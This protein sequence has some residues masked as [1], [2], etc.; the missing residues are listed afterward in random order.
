[1][2]IN[3]NEHSWAS[4]SLRFG[5]TVVTD[6]KGVKYADEIEGAEPVFGTG[7]HARGRTAGRYKVGDCSITFY[8]SGH[9]KLLQGL[10]NGFGDVRGTAVVQYRE[11]SD[12]ITDTLE[13]VRIMG[14]D[15]GA[16]DG[17]DPLEVEVK[18]SP[19]RISWN[20]K[21]LVAKAGE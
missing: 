16:E 12:V 8:K 1:M 7:R 17:T 6:I 10:P 15:G 20:G 9:K 14:G 3:G 21:Y 18:I 5:S 2:N 19:M 4:V 13:D 11:G